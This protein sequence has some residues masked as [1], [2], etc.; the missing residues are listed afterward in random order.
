MTYS[1]RYLTALEEAQEGGTLL[2]WKVVSLKL[3]V[4]L[5]L[6]ES[7]TSPRM[8]MVHMYMNRV[9]TTPHLPSPSRVWRAAAMLLRV[10]QLTC[11]FLEA[12]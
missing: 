8:L 4:R 5:P 9:R 2:A 11:L 6:A 12:I 10:L 1:R 3:A 7:E